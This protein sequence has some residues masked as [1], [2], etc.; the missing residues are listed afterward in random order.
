MNFLKTSLFVLGI[1][2][3]TNAFAMEGGVKNSIDPFYMPNSGSITWLNDYNISDLKSIASRIQYGVSDNLALE[4]GAT[5]LSSEYDTK[6]IYGY[7]GKLHDIFTLGVIYKGGFASNENVFY[8][9]SINFNSTLGGDNASLSHLGNIDDISDSTDHFMFKSAIGYSSLDGDSISLF[10]RARWV[11]D[12]SA[13]TNNVLGNLQFGNDVLAISENFM[14]VGF[15][16][17]KKLQNNFFV[18]AKYEQNFDGSDRDDKITPWLAE[19]NATYSIKEV[20]ITSYYSRVERNEI[21]G[22][23]IYGVR[24]AVKF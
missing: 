17:Q 13:R 19:V 18:G 4:F 15:E 1:S 11:L 16:G 14:T 21:V 7:G 23:D 24:F 22:R 9:S 8:K 3:S 12:E 10:G 2:L 6:D 20:D 5:Y